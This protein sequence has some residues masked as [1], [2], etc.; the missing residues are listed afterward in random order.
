MCR[1]LIF[2]M[3][4]VTR[5]LGQ[6]DSAIIVYQTNHDQF[7]PVTFVGLQIDSFVNGK[8]VTRYFSDQPSI[9]YDY[10]SLG[11][12]IS[13]TSLD[14]TVFSYDTISRII[15]VDYFR[16]NGGIWAYKPDTS[17][18][19]YFYSGNRLDST[20]K[21][22]WNGTSMVPF[23]RA[24]RLHNFSDTLF[25]ISIELFDSASWYT[26]TLV[27]VSYSPYRTDSLYANGFISTFPDEIRTY[28]SL[29]R[30]LSIINYYSGI[31]DQFQFFTY[32]CNQLETYVRS[33]FGSHNSYNYWVTFDSLCRVQEIVSGYYQMTGSNS[34][35]VFEYFYTSCNDMVVRADE[36]IR[37]CHGDTAELSVRHFGGIPPFQIIWSPNSVFPDDTSSLV[38]AAPDTSTNYLI[39]VI[40][41]NGL[42]IT[43]TLFVYVATRPLADIYISSIDTTS[44]CQSATLKCDSLNGIFYSWREI[45]TPNSISSNTEIDIIYNGTYILVAQENIS[46][47][48]VSCPA[49]IDT[50]V[51]NYFSNPA[52]VV[53]ISLE[54]NHIVAHSTENLQFQWYKNNILIA[55]SV[56]DTLFVNQ[57]ASY[58]VIGLDTSGC[59]SSV[60]YNT[61]LYQV[62]SGPL[63]LSVNVG[64]PSCDTCSD[65]YVNLQGNGGAPFYRYFINGVSH[66]HHH[67]DSLSAGVYEFCVIDH[68]H[69]MFCQQGVY[70]PVNEIASEKITYYPNPFNDKIY[71]KF[72][73]YDGFSKTR[74]RLFDSSGRIIRDFQISSPEF[75]LSRESMNSGIYF[76]LIYEESKVYG[77]G[78]VVL[79]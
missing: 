19:S 29:E 34:I 25:Q 39:T 9:K 16:K 45:S 70:L 37:I 51:F 41:S 73:S 69:C 49:A 57:F 8:L 26:D 20:V 66:A 40:D 35:D 21:S 47:W 78:K 79:N 68:N 5:A 3:L 67:I 33:H 30:V 22:I 54:C 13:M 62:P 46:Y 77:R 56:R 42:T 31:S 43:D 48:L 75:I 14:S 4:L 65:G 28:D 72:T 58:Y 15:T 44:V 64:H 24:I 60:P 74:F 50:F 61:I 2:F 6:C 38:F 23:Y 53:S 17:N 1:Y 36:D 71:F 10:D 18:V 63:S 59:E 11:R 52:P 12:L 27:T 32:Q 55:D 7:E 76:F